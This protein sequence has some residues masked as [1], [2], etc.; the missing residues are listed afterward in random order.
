MVIVKAR[1]GE[2]MDQ[3]ISRFRKKS[4]SSGILL[5]YRERERHK[6]KAEQ[7]K[8]RKYRIERMR[9]LEKKYGKKEE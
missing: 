5:E 1:P 9:E 2:S 8:E 7:R 6:T 3:L 4:L